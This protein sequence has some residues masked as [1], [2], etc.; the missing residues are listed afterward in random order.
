MLIEVIVSTLMIALIVV[1]TLTG[2]DVFNR[3]TAE[4]RRHAEATLLAAQSQEYLR[5]DPGS[6]LLSLETVAHV[7]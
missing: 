1:A 7:Y 2:F 3:A 5:S 6:A 4:E